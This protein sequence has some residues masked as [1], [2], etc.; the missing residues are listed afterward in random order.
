MSRIIPI[1]L[2]AASFAAA[3]LAGP[4]SE[5]KSTD[6]TLADATYTVVFVPGWNPESHPDSYPITHAKKGLLTPMIG[7]THDDDY[8][9]FTEG[10]KPSPGLEMLSEMGKHNP[11]DDEIRTAISA[12]NVGSL[13]ELSKG[14]AGPVHAPVS[15]SFA[16]T[17]QFSNVSLVGMI[18]P[19]PDWFYGVSAVKLFNDGAWVPSIVVE[20]YAWDSGGDAG[21]TYL[22]DDRDLESKQTTRPSDASYFAP[23]GNKAPV[24]Y[25]IFKRIPSSATSGM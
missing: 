19:S 11:L 16:V 17:E 12:G 23:N 9:L 24:G 8:R 1:T 2:F 21:T 22:A 4:P 20:A 3:V 6:P 15:Y 25:F 18:A 13:I 14:S 7:A 10:R 5:E